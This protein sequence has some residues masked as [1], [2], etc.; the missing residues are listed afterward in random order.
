MGI[1]LVF[2]GINK[3][4]DDTESLLSQHKIMLTEASQNMFALKEAIES[5][6]TSIVQD[7]LSKHLLGNK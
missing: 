4:E 5:F 7:L 3:P 6:D 2:S 1:H